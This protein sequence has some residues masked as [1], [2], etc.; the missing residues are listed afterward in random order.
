MLES[1]IPTFFQYFISLFFASPPL[2]LSETI[3]PILF[4]SPWVI[5]CWVFPSFSV[6]LPSFFNSSS[7]PNAFAVW[8]QNLT[9]SF[10]YIPPFSNKDWA[11]SVIIWDKIIIIPDVIPSASVTKWAS[12][13]WLLS[14]PEMNA[15]LSALNLASSLIAW[16]AWNPSPASCSFLI[17]DILYGFR[18]RLSSF[19]E[20]KNALNACFNMLPFSVSLNSMLPSSFITISL[21]IFSITNVSKSLSNP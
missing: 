8:V 6:F 14:E 20:A 17:L 11:L 19:I 13:L 1:F 7:R 16:Y 3:L 4:K 5:F 9:A 2:S 18:I 10:V 12:Y 15:S 21:L